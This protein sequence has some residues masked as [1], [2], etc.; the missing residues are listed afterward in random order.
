MTVEVFREWL[1]QFKQGD[2][3]MMHDEESGLL[4]PVGGAVHGTGIVELVPQE[5]DDEG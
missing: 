2:T 1:L 4:Q 3:V 5:D